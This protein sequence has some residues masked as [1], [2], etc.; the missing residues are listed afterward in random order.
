MQ[1]FR[2]SSRVWSHPSKHHFEI[3]NTDWYQLWRWRL[4][5]ASF[6]SSIFLLFFGV[7][8]YIFH[9]LR[10]CCIEAIHKDATW[11]IITIEWERF[12]FMRAWV[13]AS[14]VCM[15]HLCI[16]LRGS[17]YCLCPDTCALQIEWLLLN[18]TNNIIFQSHCSIVRVPSLQFIFHS[19]L[20]YSDSTVYFSYLDEA[21]IVCRA[22]T[23]D[24]F[25]LSYV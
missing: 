14:L 17:V 24:R 4:C 12:P 11:H 9:L 21:T 7:Y 8:L 19:I 16:S 6:L 23:V 15:M 13:L 18:T 25:C 10:V 1:T 22:N 20:R 2:I 3:F 5:V